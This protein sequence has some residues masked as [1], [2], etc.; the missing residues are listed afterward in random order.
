MKKF[1]GAI[2]RGRVGWRSDFDQKTPLEPKA[3]AALRSFVEE[4]IDG[5]FNYLMISLR[6][7]FEA[8]LHKQY[9]LQA[10]QYYTV[11]AWFLH[12][13]R[14]R[15]RHALEAKKKVPTDL[16]K[17]PSADIEETE[18]FAVIGAVTNHE[19]MVKMFTQ[20]GDWTDEKRHNDIQSIMRCFT[21]LIYTVQDM[22]ISQNV[23]DQEIA[24]NMQNRMFYEESMLEMV[25]TLLRSYTMQPFK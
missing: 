15:R 16:S 12:A 9:E 13:E 3:R 24:E 18:S 4:F 11:V 14:V 20:I 17:P 7:T 19:F 25:P 22:A 2:D 8:D 5:C 21:Q 23:E 1:R 6:R 10:K